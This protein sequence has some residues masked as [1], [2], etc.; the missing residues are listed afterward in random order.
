MAVFIQKGDPVMFARQAIKRGLQLFE[1]EKMQYEREAGLLMG[2]QEYVEW[3]NQ[4][5]VDYQIN[6]SNN[7]FNGQLAEYRKATA[8]LSQ[9]RLADGKPEETIETPTGQYDEEGNEIVS[10]TVIPAIEPLDAQVEGTIYDEQGNATT[11]MVDNPKIVQDEIER[12]E[13]QTI[14]DATPQEVKDFVV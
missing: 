13:A 1:A 3:A 4:W 10:V 5:L 7:T 12:T 11:S 14:V 2:S 9:Y 8:R 6:T